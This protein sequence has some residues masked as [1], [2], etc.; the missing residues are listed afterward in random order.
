MSASDSPKSASTNGTSSSKSSSAS[1]ASRSATP[2]SSSSSTFARISPCALPKP[3]SAG[4]DC[5]LA[6]VAPLYGPVLGLP[7]A[8]AHPCDV[9]QQP[10]PAVLEPC[11]ELSALHRAA[12][13][14]Q[15]CA[16]ELLACEP[17][18]APAVSPHR[19]SSC[20]LEGR[21]WA[22]RFRVACCTPRSEF[23]APVTCTSPEKCARRFRHA[24]RPGV[25]HDV[26]V[27]S[28]TDP[29]GRYAAH[30]HRHQAV[31][32]VAQCPVTVHVCG[33]GAHAQPA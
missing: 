10:G 28:C 18:R 32:G 25:T 14:E 22:P 27:D 8:T 7:R 15:C 6:S 3:H 23:Q 13:P 24:P 9:A 31:G 2:T 17:Q 5:K 19:S 33:Q 30:L 21:G 1:C 16:S 20:Q 26:L 11:R 29:T 4:H 12:D